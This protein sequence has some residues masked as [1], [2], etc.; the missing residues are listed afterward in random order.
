MRL[1]NDDN[2]SYGALYFFRAE[3]P[4]KGSDYGYGQRV[5]HNVA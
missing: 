3:V 1:W 5:K 4:Y 2:Y